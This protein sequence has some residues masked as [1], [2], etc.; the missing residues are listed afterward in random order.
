MGLLSLAACADSGSRDA[1]DAAYD[2]QDQL[3]RN[4]MADP[5]MSDP[6]ITGGG[7]GD[8]HDQSMQRDLNN[9]FN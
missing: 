5:T 4:P 1:A 2:R 6:D 8:Y 7:F 9:A 3:L